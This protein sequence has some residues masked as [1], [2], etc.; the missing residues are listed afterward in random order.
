MLDAKLTNLANVA[1]TLDGT[2]TIAIDQ[3]T[4]LTSGSMTVT[5]GWYTFPGLTDID[6][7]SLSVQNGGKLA[8]GMVT[9]YSQP[10]EDGITW[11]AE[12]PGSTL[13]LPASRGWGSFTAGLFLC[14]HF[15]GAK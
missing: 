4:S 15:K 3:W 1:V 9:T 13:S 2:G 5:G 10:E 14:R 7:S 12:G 6:S 11:S 8:L